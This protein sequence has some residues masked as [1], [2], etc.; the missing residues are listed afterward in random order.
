M[1]KRKGFTLIE[2]LVVISIVALLIAILI[3]A[4]Q[5]ARAQAKDILCQSNLH[6]WGV[7][8][9][10]YADNNNG[11]FFEPSTNWRKNHWIEQLRSYYSNPKILRC[12][13]ATKPVSEG[14]QNPFAAWGVLGANWAGRAVAEIQQ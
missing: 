12:P 5:R 8:F 13:E 3:P 7:I 1:S 2:L 11:Y 6:Q 4:L 9:S 14:G 10:M